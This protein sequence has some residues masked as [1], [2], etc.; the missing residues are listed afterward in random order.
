MVQ[1]MEVAKA[2]IAPLIQLQSAC[3]EGETIACSRYV[4]SYDSLVGITGCKCEAM[5]EQKPFK[6]ERRPASTAMVPQLK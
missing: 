2:I 4:G 1:I 6:L 5:P 3:A